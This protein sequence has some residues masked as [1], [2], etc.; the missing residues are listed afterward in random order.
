MI[1]SILNCIITVTKNFTIMENIN[2]PH[3]LFNGALQVGPSFDNNTF[4]NVGKGKGMDLIRVLVKMMKGELKIKHELG[5]D[6]TFEITIPSNDNSAHSDTQPLSFSPN[7]SSSNRINTF[8]Q[9]VR[10]M[11]LENIDDENFGITELCRAIGIS[12]SQLH[13]K[14]KANTGLSTSIYIRFIRLERANHLLKHSDLNISE[15]AYEVGFKDPSYFSRLF[16]ERFGIAP[17]KVRQ[18]ENAIR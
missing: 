11:I 2:V 1:S 9:K 8:I 18:Q 10:D 16:C 17:S 12:R 3:Q 13:N 7:E 15:V 14:I 6:M 4:A 5:A